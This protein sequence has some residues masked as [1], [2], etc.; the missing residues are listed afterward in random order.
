[1]ADFLWLKAEHQGNTRGDGDEEFLGITWPY[2]CRAR[3]IYSG[4]LKVC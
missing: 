2:S 1:M 3:T 4:P